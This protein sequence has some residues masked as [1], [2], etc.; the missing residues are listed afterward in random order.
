ME[1]RLTPERE[2][3][4]EAVARRQGKDA[5]TVANEALASWLDYQDWAGEARQKIEEA[6]R[7]ADDPHTAWLTPEESRADLERRK[8]QWLKRRTD[9]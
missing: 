4:L 7:Q 3:Q 5:A 9:P 8:E 2:A 1:I 6:W